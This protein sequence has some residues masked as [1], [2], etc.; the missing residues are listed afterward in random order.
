M[1]ESVR[2]Q[3]AAKINLHLRV[4]G[5]RKDG[6]HSILSIFQ[7]VSLA[8]TIVIRSL[9]ESDTIE[10]DGD[11]DCPAKDT[12][13]YKAIVTYRKASGIRTG[14]LVKVDKL[15][16]AGAGLG[17]GS[18]DAAATL[19]GLQAVLGGNLGSSTIEE[20][21]ASLGSDVPF[22]LSSAAAIVSGRGEKVR[23]LE[24]R[25][26]FSLL[27]VFP[28]F[29]V[30]TAD[31]Y[32]LLDRARPDDSGEADPGAQALIDAYHGEIS[33][34]PFANSFEPIIGGSRPEIPKAK[35]ILQDAGASFA[36]MSGSGSSVFGVF[37]VGSRTE[38]A[39]R[40]LTAAGFRVYAAS[41]LARCSTLD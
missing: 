35:A 10:I 40:H 12:T 32:A 4:Y 27:I 29:P 8:D 38:E 41:P 30:A 11:F 19:L 14:L 36:S 22:F 28:G 39:Q 20:L 33:S 24:A 1:A 37:K 9:K 5:R 34:W 15:I 17:G 23:Q 7:A 16:P 25:E 6:F 18:S 13:V 31:A 2:V 21:G 26:D 3:A